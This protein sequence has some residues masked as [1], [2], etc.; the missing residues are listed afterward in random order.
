MSGMDWLSIVILVLLAIDFIIGFKR[1][2]IRQVFD[3]LGIVLAVLAAARFG[4]AA[5][6]SIVRPLLPAA[7]EQVVSVLGF[8]VV[9]L[10][11]LVV[12]ELVSHGVG[13]IAKMPGLSVLNGL[14][15]ALFR[16]ARGAILISVV[17]SLVVALE[18]PAAGEL[19]QGSSIAQTLQPVAG[20]LWSELKDYVP[21]G[22]GIPDTGGYQNVEPQPSQPGGGRSL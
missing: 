13:L 12:M 10:A 22:L 8:V 21:G 7:S 6:V 20:L 2:L 4:P 11:T 16:V 3:L 14:G 9:F 5:T 19:I 15:G 17:L 1:G 18:I